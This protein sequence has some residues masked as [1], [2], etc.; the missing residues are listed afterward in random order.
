VELLRFPEKSENFGRGFLGAFFVGVM[1]TFFQDPQSRTGN[2][3][4][5]T[6]PEAQPDISIFSP[7]D[8]QNGKFQA[9]ITL[10]DTCVC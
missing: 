10:F 6:L 8:N 1:P 7:P 4:M 9:S 2:I 5:K 3:T